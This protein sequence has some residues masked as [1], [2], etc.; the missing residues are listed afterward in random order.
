MRSIREKRDRRE[1]G[2]K[3][4]ERDQKDRRKNKQKEKRKSRERKKMTIHRGGRERV[5]WADAHLRMKHFFLNFYECLSLTQPTT[6]TITYTHTHTLSLS[7]FSFSLFLSFS[8]FFSLSW[9]EQLLQ[10]WMYKYSISFP[11]THLPLGRILCYR[12]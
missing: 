3:E 1:T 2:R 9:E 12:C 4:K 11:L 8:L 5:E 6:N 7:F 10:L